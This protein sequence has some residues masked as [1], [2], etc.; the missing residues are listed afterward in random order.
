MRGWLRVNICS[1]I[2]KETSTGRVSDEQKV[3]IKSLVEQLNNHIRN[4]GLQGIS[5]GRSGVVIHDY[6]CTNGFKNI[7]AELKDCCDSFMPRV[8]S[9]YTVKNSVIFC[10]EVSKGDLLRPHRVMF[11]EAE[12][13]SKWVEKRCRAFVLDP[14]DGSKTELL[15]DLVIV[16]EGLISPNNLKIPNWVEGRK[17]PFYSIVY[18]DSDKTVYRTIY[19]PKESNDLDLIWNETK[20]ENG[21]SDP[22]Y[23]EFFLR[24]IR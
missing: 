17:D 14:S 6:Q 15:G 23:C 2:K 1:H 7:H 18:N 19:I 16:H 24:N 8:D 4:T 13:N 3:S 11:S 5:K 21:A 9:G 10:G 12:I 22:S 20:N